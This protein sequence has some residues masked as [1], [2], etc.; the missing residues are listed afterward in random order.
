MGS[1]EDADMLALIA[2]APELATPDDTEV[3]LDAS[4][5]PPQAIAGWVA[6]LDAVFAQHH[7][8]AK[9]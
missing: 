3:L 9:E 6:E 7:A 5:A 8:A 4:F 2:A 1:P